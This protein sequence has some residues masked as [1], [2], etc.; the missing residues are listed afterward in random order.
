MFFRSKFESADRRLAL[1][2]NFTKQVFLTAVQ[3]AEVEEELRPA[4]R[5]ILNSP[6]VADFRA[7]FSAVRAAL[8]AAVWVCCRNPRAGVRLRLAPEGSRL[9][10]C[11]CQWRLLFSAPPPLVHTRRV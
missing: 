7:V 6:P 4:L 2:D 11:R 8:V 3:E 5:A 1:S 10:D 9:G